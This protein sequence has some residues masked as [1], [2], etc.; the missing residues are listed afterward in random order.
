VFL[1]HVSGVSH[2]LNLEGCVVKMIPASDT[3]FIYDCCMDM[4]EAMT[5]V[6]NG[7]APDVH[8]AVGTTK[9]TLTTVKAVL[10]KVKL[11]ICKYKDLTD[12]RNR[13]L[14]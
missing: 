9:Q 12:G 14:V 6:S 5:T 10:N 2:I 3:R 1:V 7:T 8:G 4:E 13:T 11:E